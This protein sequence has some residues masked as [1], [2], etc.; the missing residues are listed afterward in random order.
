MCQRLN[1]ISIEIGA[2]EN[3]IDYRFSHLK[4]WQRGH[5]KQTEKKWGGKSERTISSNDDF[6]SLNLC[7]FGWLFLFFVFFFAVFGLWNIHRKI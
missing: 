5:S 1:D 6:L 4:I 2:V 3:K 7:A